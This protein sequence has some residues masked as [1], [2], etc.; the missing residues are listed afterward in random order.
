[1]GCELCIEVLT[2]IWSLEA[3]VELLPASRSALETNRVGIT[4]RI[5]QRTLSRQMSQHIVCT[6]S[7]YMKKRTVI[8]DKRHLVITHKHLHHLSTSAQ[9]VPPH[10]VLMSV[11]QQLTSVSIRR[12]GLLIVATGF[13]THS[14]QSRFC[15]AWSWFGRPS[16][17]LFL[18]Q[19]LDCAV[20]A[21]LAGSDCGLVL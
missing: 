9:S 4:D 10:L 21:W 16:G 1:M 11:C 3:D 14:G 12:F 2:L 5:W 6:R 17:Q 20:V 13:H 8:I 18:P 7:K 19:S 15:C